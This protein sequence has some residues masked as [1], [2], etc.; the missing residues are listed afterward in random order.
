[1][2]REG[3]RKHQG[4]ADLVVDAEASHRLRSKALAISAAA[5]PEITYRL[6]KVPSRR[7]RSVTSRACWRTRRAAINTSKEN[8]SPPWR[9]PATGPLANHPNQSARPP[10][11]RQAQNHRRACRD[12]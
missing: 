3:Q 12:Q 6:D 9:L 2:T 4:P 8:D 1:M 7:V 11:T 10:E 5:R